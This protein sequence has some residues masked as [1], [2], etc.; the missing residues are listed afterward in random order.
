MKSKLLPDFQLKGARFIFT[1]LNEV[2]NNSRAEVLLY[3]KQNWI[4]TV[5]GI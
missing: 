3:Q 1:V 2:L 5:N 4:T